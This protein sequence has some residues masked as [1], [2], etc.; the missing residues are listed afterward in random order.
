MAERVPVIDI[1]P[2]FTDGPSCEESRHVAQLIHEAASKWGFF[3]ITNTSV[4]PETQ[5]AL[6][7]S[8]RAFFDLPEEIKLALDVRAGGPA[9]R[10][11]MPLGGEHTHGSLDWKE[12]LYVGPEH[13]DKH[14]L[15]GMPLHGKNQF[16]DHALPEMRHDVLE[17]L[18]QVTELGKTLTDIFSL[19]LGLE[20]KELRQ[21]LIEPEPVVLFRCFKYAPLQE[22]AALENGDEGYG[23]GEHTDFG[24]LTILKVESPGLQIVSPSGH[25][26]DVPLIE[27]AFV[28][29]GK[30]YLTNHVHNF[31]DMFDQLTGGRYPSR[32]HRVLRP[33]PG[34]QPRLSFPCFFDFSWEAEMKKLP[35]D[36]LTPLSEEEME[37][38]R[39]RWAGGTFRE[40]RGTWSQYLAR[41][42]QKV[43]PH[44][45]LPDFE[46][47][48]A[49]STRFTRSV[50]TASA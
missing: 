3:M 1:A 10:G 19:A 31:G 29:N 47:N 48:T 24:Y 6:V 16:P 7:S 8:A 40:V 12:G 46:P 21:R 32:R 38:A 20:H 50:E 35:L 43:F 18:Q 15:Y 23:I 2:Y 13:G 45:K 33:P 39:Q 37:L 5:S 36:H 9:W 26:V 4:D 49:P 14:T 28:V 42:V 41:K 30:L 44:L 25:W 17:Y 27:N 22:K 11:Y 34:S